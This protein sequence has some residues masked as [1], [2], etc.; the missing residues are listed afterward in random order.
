MSADT[1]VGM[2]NKSFESDDI[3]P[4]FNGLNYKLF[5]S[6]VLPVL[7]NL[8]EELSTKHPNILQEFIELF[9]SWYNIDS[10]KLVKNVRKLI[11][12]DQVNDWNGKKRRMAPE[13]KNPLI[14]R[15]CDKRV[16]VQVAAIAVVE[17]AE[18]KKLRQ[19]KNFVE[20]TDR[21]T[22]CKMTSRQFS[23]LLMRL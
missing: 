21:D 23:D 13:E 6:A 16:K 22:L 1:V 5:Q 18:M 2:T 12:L 9:P 20:N 15:C 11:K 19:L 7:G 10:E 17:A 14:K 3:K 8:S 4:T